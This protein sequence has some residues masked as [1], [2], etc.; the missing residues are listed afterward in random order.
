MWNHTSLSVHKCTNSSCCLLSSVNPILCLILPSVHPCLSLWAAWPRYPLVPPGSGA[1][2]PC[3]ATVPSKPLVMAA[4][5]PAVAACAH[6]RPPAQ[7]LSR[8][9]Y[10][11]QTRASRPS[12]G[13]LSSAWF[14]LGV[15]NSPVPLHPGNRNEMRGRGPSV[16][17]DRSCVCL[18]GGGA[19]LSSNLWGSSIKE[20]GHNRQPWE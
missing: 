10:L 11:T 17:G 3:F 7:S 9:I 15:S 2:H 19:C 20:N 1:R 8:P 14:S 18:R 4:L 13:Y 16:L 5:A 12:P 6:S